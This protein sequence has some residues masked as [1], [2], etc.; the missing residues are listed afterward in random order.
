M[1]LAGGG[2]LNQVCV[3]T[4]GGPRQQKK[5]DKEM[6]EMTKLEQSVVINRPTEEV[7]AFVTDIEKTNYQVSQ[8]MPDRLK[9]GFTALGDELFARVKREE[10]D[11]AEMYDDYPI[12]ILLQLEDLGL[13]EKGKGGQF[14]DEHDITFKGDFPINTGGGQL[15][16][17]QPSG[18]G[19][20]LHVVEAVRQLKIEDIICALFVLA[21]S[22]YPYH[23]CLLRT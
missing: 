17:G 12:A 9:T 18:A 3:G 14:I 7:F 1:A 21:H 4:E 13:C 16:A 20:M 23:I 8:P 5:N 2:V 6:I 15:S 22:V 19:S 10:I 11:F